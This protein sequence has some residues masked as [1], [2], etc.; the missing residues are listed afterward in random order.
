[1]RNI[2]LKARLRDRQH[3]LAVCEALAAAPQGDLWQR[4]TYFP[5]AEGRFKMREV[6]PGEDY[7]VFYR[8]ADAITARGC[9]YAIE[10]VRTSM[11]A[12]LQEA[13]GT[14]AVVEKV[15][16]LYMWHNVR[17]HLDRVMDLGDFIEFEAVLDAT[18]DDADG[19]E[20]L[21]LLQHAFAIETD[22]LEP[23]SYLDLCLARVPRPA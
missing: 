2:E 22:D 8:R 3:V 7:L 13:L 10:P 12:V 23:G 20:K 16:T 1:M 4:D 5:V 11:R 18:H 6:E 19:Y 14:L 17:I 9:D 21:H 15:R